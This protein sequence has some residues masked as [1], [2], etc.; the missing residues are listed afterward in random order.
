L[1]SAKFPV[2]QLVEEGLDELGAQVAVVDV[3]GVFPH[4]DGQQ[5]LVGGGQRRA[6]GAGVDDVHAAVG[7]LHQP[8]PARAE[9]ADGALLTKASLKAA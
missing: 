6:G 7:F 9:V 1:A 5:G 8:G 3:V 4:V 2:H